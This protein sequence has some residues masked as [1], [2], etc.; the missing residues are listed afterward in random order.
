MAHHARVALLLVCLILT[1]PLLASP[2][3]NNDDSCDIALL[4]AATLLLPYFEVNLEN[5][6]GP[7]TLFTVTN[8]SAQEQIAHVTLWTDYGYPVIDFN[9]YLTGYDVQSIDLFDVIV[10]GVIAPDL[11]TG[12]DISAQGDYSSSNEKLDLSNCDELPGVIP[13]V[14]VSR[15]KKAFTLGRVDAFGTLPACTNVG[16]THTNA[17]GYATIDVVRLCT[18]RTPA[19]AGYLTEDILWDNVLLGDYQQVDRSQN[20]SEGD[21]MVHIRAISEGGTAAERRN[22]PNQYEVTFH[23]TFYS[24]FLPSSNK[25]FDARQPLPALFAGRWIDGGGAEFRT[26]FKIWREGRTTLN[27]PCGTYIQNI[28]G[29]IDAVVFDEEENP[30]GMAPTDVICTPII[31]YPVL[32][33]T[34]MTDVRDTTVF[35]RPTTGAVAGWVYFN[36]DNCWRD[37][38]ASQNWVVTSMR[39]LGRASVDMTA[40]AL[41]NGCTPPLEQ[42]EVNWTAGIVIGPAENINP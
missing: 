23:R 6:S 33:A 24:R 34:S 9:I 17:V 5:P 2:T 16:G 40:F 20:L 13:A 1:L 4:P 26:K 41:G 31:T 3:R 37:D 22:N 42:S 21:T 27:A 32:P 15:M 25:T 38:Y 18:V 35:P 39:A 28:A 14:Y 19:D 10:R 12:T 8:A 30:E 36:L 11:G 29:F 7:T